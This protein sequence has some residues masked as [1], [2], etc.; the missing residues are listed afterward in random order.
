MGRGPGLVVAFPCDVH[1]VW[2]SLSCQ[3]TQAALS[4]V[5][6][7]ASVDVL[8]ALAQF[9]LPHTGFLVTMTSTGF[10]F[11][12]A[13]PCYPPSLWSCIS[14]CRVS[15]STVRW[16]M[17]KDPS[18]WRISVKALDELTVSLIVTFGL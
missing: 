3:A 2:G 16:L 11:D 4:R 15:Y 5:C 7:L 9:M 13:C 1:G 6:V 12:W 18:C 14:T 10:T 17:A 8:I